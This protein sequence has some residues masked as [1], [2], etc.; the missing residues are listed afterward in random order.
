[1]G[2]FWT[3]QGISKDGCCWLWGS[4]FLLVFFL[5]LQRKRASPRYPWQ[6][7]TSVLEHHIPPPYMDVGRVKMTLNIFK[8]FKVITTCDIFPN[9][10]LPT[11][12]EKVQWIFWSRRSRLEGRNRSLSACSLVGS[13]KCTSGGQRA[14]L[15]TTFEKK[16][17][18]TWEVIKIPVGWVI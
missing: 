6:P 13:I 1:M 11:W 7:G 5:G 4:Q 2:I 12:I 8:W 15:K 17:E 9:P 3:I 14:Q 18:L 10:R 16:D